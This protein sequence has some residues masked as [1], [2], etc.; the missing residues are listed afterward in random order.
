V[1]ANLADEDVVYVALWLKLVEDR[2]KVP[3]D[4]T[5]E[6]AFAAVDDDSGWPAKLRAFGNGRLGGDG[7]LKAARDRVEKTEALFY[8]A[9]AL[10]SAQED[11]RALQQL[12]QVAQSEAIQLVEVTIARDLLSQQAPLDLQVPKDVDVP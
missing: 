3:S 10:R 2:L 7:L 9:M 1:E 12:E 8:G 5:K 6:E 11:Q 4:G